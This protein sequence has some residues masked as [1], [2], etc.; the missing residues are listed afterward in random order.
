MTVHRTARPRRAGL[1]SRLRRATRGS[2][3]VEF[4]IL[5]PVL[6]ALVYGTIEL[7]RIVGLRAELQDALG[8]ALRAATAQ[9][10]TSTSALRARVEERLRLGEPGSVS[11]FEVAIDAP[12]AGV[13][14]VRLT[15]RYRV[16]LLVSLAGLGP[17]ELEV[18]A[19]GYRES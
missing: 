18:Q 4:A 9:G 1:W 19:A 10:L 16:G 17:I 6:V 2:A 12:A 5:A 3:A 13:E 15:L 11:G 14:R 8:A 7:A